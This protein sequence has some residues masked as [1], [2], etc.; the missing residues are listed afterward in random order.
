[1]RIDFKSIK[2]FIAPY[3]GILQFC[4]VLVLCHFFWKYTVLGDESG[5]AVTFFGLNISAPFVWMS[6]HLT[7]AVQKLL[8]FFGGNVVKLGNDVLGFSN[9][10]SVHIVW[11][12]S[13]I[14]QAYIFTCIILCSRGKWRDKAWFIPSGIL[15]CFLINVVRI[16]ILVA[17]IEHN[18]ET[19]VILHEYVLKYLFYG[20]IFLMW[21]LWQ[22]KIVDQVPSTDTSKNEIQN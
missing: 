21:V 15:V 2:R 7:I 5:D 12:C 20:I 22:E 4:V 10:H 1:M 18:Y 9:G 3:G 13:G 6:E 8:N 11:A 14:K 16:T 17:V 19:F